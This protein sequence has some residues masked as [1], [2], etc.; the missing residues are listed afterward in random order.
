LIL[1]HK[2]LIIAAVFVLAAA[3]LLLIFFSRSPV[4]IVTDQSSVLLYGASRSRWEMIR[5]SLVLFRRVRA[6]AVVDD[7]GDDIL[8]FAIADVSEKP[9]CVLFPLRFARAMRFY[10]E[11][12]PEIPVV[13]LEGRYPEW[14]NPAFYAIGD[15]MDDFFIF[16]TDIACDFYFA[17]LAAAALD[18]GKNGKIAVFLESS[19]Q[20]EAQEAFLRALNDLE[21]QLETTFFTSFA[22]YLEMPDISCVVI[23]GAGVDF[24]ENSSGIP[25]IFFTWLDPPLIP[26]DVAMVFNDSPWT[27]T[28]DAVRMVSS[29]MA[30]GLIPSKREILPTNGVDRNILKKLRN[31]ERN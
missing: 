17:G 1:R 27:Q 21:K 13:L 31:L 19:F 30:T 3:V 8:Q 9:F 4:L 5:S 26:V 24:F 28:V 20:T 14:A 15:I 6:V 25:V 23:A 11:Q 7:A 2:I 10:R 12:N 18:N 22:Q 29:R 16:K